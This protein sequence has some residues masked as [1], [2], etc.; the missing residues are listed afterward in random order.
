MARDTTP[1]LDT[2]FES[3]KRRRRTARQKTNPI[4]SPVA[5]PTKA[6]SKRPARR[7][8]LL[9]PSSTTILVEEQTN[10]PRRKQTPSVVEY[11]LDDWVRT[12]TTRWRRSTRTKSIP[13]PNAPKTTVDN[14]QLTVVPVED[15]PIS[16]DFDS[17]PTR[18]RKVSNLNSDICVNSILIATMFRR[19]PLSFRSG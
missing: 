4:T 10:N 17:I 16:V 13:M 3:P 11:H 6:K 8:P 14:S 12:R 18:V 5:L 9:G 1:F 19:T 15:D 2:A 7:Q